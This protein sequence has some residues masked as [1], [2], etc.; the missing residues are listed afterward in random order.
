MVEPT[1]A[2]LR[3]HVAWQ[4]DG[5]LPREGSKRI[6]SA[7]LVLLDAGGLMDVTPL[8]EV[9]GEQLEAVLEEDPTS[10]R[11]A[12]LAGL[13]FMA[14]AERDAALEAFGRL[15][16]EDLTHPRR[17]ALADEVNRIDRALQH[18]GLL[19]RDL[20]DEA[21]R[22]PSLR[23]L[24]EL[25]EGD[26]DARR[27]AAQEAMRRGVNVRSATRVVAFL[28]EPAPAYEHDGTI[29]STLLAQ[30]TAAWK[31][32]D[33]ATAKACFDRALARDVRHEE[34]DVVVALVGS[35]L[36]RT[37]SAL[38]AAREARRELVLETIARLTSMP[39]SEVR[40][41][42][43]LMHRCDPVAVGARDFAE[44][45]RLQLAWHGRPHE[46]VE[47]A[48]RSIDEFARDVDY[49]ELGE[50][51]GWRVIELKRARAEFLECQRTPLERLVVGIDEHSSDLVIERAGPE[52][53]VRAG[54]RGAVPASPSSDLLR[55]ARAL[56]PKLADFV[57]YGVERLIPIPVEVIAPEA[58]LTVAQVERLLEG[59][60]VATPWGVM[61][62]NHFVQRPPLRR[63]TP[64][65]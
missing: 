17:V 12:L 37:T 3:A 62:M 24:A 60:L 10:K 4:L 51:T 30:A 21:R 43:A 22:D 57:R 6:V 2:Q 8:L 28:D 7:L 52:L 36:S 29:V 40:H 14:A 45:V 20:L 34:R 46:L 64:P 38:G 23:E 59:V 42:L 27:T 55:L 54:M 1:L 44:L 16:A 47:L 39:T 18:V 5:Q 11:A 63:G 56:L 61:A 33:L 41:V 13:S 9:A 50:R 49:A 32:G 53:T 31:A 19:K 65:R 25:L 48:D 58:G 26:T 35:L 15:L